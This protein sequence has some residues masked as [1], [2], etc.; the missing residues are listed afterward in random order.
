MKILPDGTKYT[1]DWEDGKANGLGIKQL[2]NGTVYEGNW[3]DGKFDKGKCTYP[4]GKIYDGKWKDGKPF[5]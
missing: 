2:P 3:I 1:G 4:D 5:G